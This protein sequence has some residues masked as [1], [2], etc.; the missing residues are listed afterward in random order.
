M[1]NRINKHIQVDQIKNAVALCKEVGMRVFGSFIVGLP[2]ETHE[3]LMDSHKL[4]LEIDVL[5]GYH[6]LAPFPGTTI[7]EKLKDYDLEVLTRDWTKFDA[8]QAIVKTSSLTPEDIIGFVEEYYNKK[9][10]SDEEDLA[11]RREQGKCTPTELLILE[12]NRKM[13]VV[14]AVLTQDV[15]ES[16]DPFP[17]ANGNELGLL[18]EAISRRIDKNPDVIQTAM[19]YLIRH[20]Y[21][22]KHED[23][24]SIRW[25]WA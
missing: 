22:K 18:A 16:L 4:A 21:L 13:D 1:L 25:V 19:G 14:Y 17:K 15:I 11:R 12:G 10:R 20:G 23:T 6:F 8:N 9:I 24:G 5:Y 3:T 2:G 7:M